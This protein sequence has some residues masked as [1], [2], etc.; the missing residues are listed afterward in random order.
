[1]LEN[2]CRPI[3]SQYI[4]AWEPSIDNIR[5][6]HALFLKYLLYLGSCFADLREVCYK[7]G[8]SGES[9]YCIMS[10]HKHVSSDIIT[11]IEHL[12]QLMVLMTCPA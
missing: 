8:M 3:L 10:C 9:Y 6:Y 12:E 1:M 5:A 11:E 4:K 7:Q 2:D